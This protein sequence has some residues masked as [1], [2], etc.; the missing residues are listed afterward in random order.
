M[1]PEG[2]LPHSQVSNTCPYP[3]PHQS[4]PC[5]P[6]HFLFIHLN[7]ILPSKPRS[8]KWSLPVRLSHENLLWTSPVFH[9][10]HMPRPSHSAW[11]DPP[12]N[13]CWRVKIMKLLVRQSSP[14]SYYL[15]PV[16][17]KYLP[18]HPIVEH[19]QTVPPSTW[20]ISFTPTQNN[21]QNCISVYTT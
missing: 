20:K 16:R 5:P 21:T 18:Q 9:T 13:I 12:N 6:S 17:P 14:L 10:C 1:K 8:V 3:E 2:S 11:L 19:P 15:V 7:T 4:S